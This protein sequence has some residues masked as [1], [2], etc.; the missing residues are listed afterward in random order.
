M[1]VPV[2]TTATAGP[3]P[4][5]R[6]RTNE[7]L[8]R[9]LARVRAK[10]REAHV[11]RAHGDVLLHEL[12]REVEVERWRRHDHVHL[13]RVDLD[14]VEHVNEVAHRLLRAVLFVQTCVL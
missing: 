5:W 13:L 12:E 8:G 6:A 2:A 1:L 9:D 10:A 3:L 4:A 7:V 11:L 14:L